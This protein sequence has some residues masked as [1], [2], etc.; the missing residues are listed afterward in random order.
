MSEPDLPDAP[1]SGRLLD[2]QLHLLGRQML[3]G[4]GDP[5]CIVD[6]LRIDGISFGVDQPPSASRPTVNAVLTGAVLF[7]R[8]FGGRP[9]VSRLQPI[10]WS[11]VR[12]VGVVVR[13]DSTGSRFDTPWI[14][15]WLRERLIT[16]IP[17]GRHAAQ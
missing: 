14:E 2:A 10:P 12:D 3:D 1:H 6:D 11:S 4:D 17:G 15:R 5:V 13:V 9:P 16:H 8:V 7:T